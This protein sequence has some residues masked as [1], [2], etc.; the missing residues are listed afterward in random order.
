[1]K[2]KLLIIIL[3]IISASIAGY[4]LISKEKPINVNGY[5]TEK[6]LVELTVNNTRAGTIKAC[7]RA[8]IS[9]IIGGQIEKLP[10]KKGSQVNEGDILLELW[11]KDLVSELNTALKEREAVYKRMQEACA[12][13]E[14]TKRTKAR[15]SDIHNKKLVS[16][17]EFDKVSIEVKT[18]GME[19]DSQKAAL[20][21]S[22]S[23]ISTA[24]SFIEK[25]TI[26]ATFSGTIAEING[27]IG[28][29]VT[30]SPVGV[31]TLPVIDLID[32][33]CL[34]VSAPIDE[35]DAPVVKTGMYAKITVDAFPK[36]EFKG[37]IRRIA[38]YAQEFEKQA[39]TVE[40][41]ANFSEDI[42]IIDMLP[43]YSADL[44][45]TV[46]K[47][48]NTI[49]IPT[50]ALIN[51]KSVFIYNPSDKKISKKDVQKGISNWKFTQIISGLN[52]GDIVVTS[53]E[54]E[55][56]KE[57]ALVNIENMKE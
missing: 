47:V 42:S 23:R 36:K 25:T 24:K 57:G 52:D 40:V 34:Y 44:E 48:E 12:R 1:V 9:P 49:R 14:K 46:D 10:F 16:E 21:A 41:E 18:T 6:G 54:R 28:E 8:R 15:Y 56:V 50:E 51:E 26:K 37:E 38:P 30:P 31:A 2:I 39:R 35:M 27:E 5:K 4:L 19:C 22:E 13:H 29:Y 20:D 43:G 45:I 53:I 17:E 3:L 11:N 32:K 55:G 7:N 33:S